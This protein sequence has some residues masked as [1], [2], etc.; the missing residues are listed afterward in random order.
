MVLS[1][2]RW[3][4]MTVSTAELSV[5]EVAQ[6]R[7]SGGE[8]MENGVVCVEYLERTGNELGGVPV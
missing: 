5:K 7:E 6:L 1:S 4:S 3:S 8:A 2:C